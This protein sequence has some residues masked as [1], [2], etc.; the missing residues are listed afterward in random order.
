MALT[1]S[2]PAWNPFFRKG[3]GD[4][5]ARLKTVEQKIAET[6]ASMGSPPPAPH[7]AAAGNQDNKW[8]G[9]KARWAQHNEMVKK[10]KEYA[11]GYRA[12]HAND[13]AEAAGDGVHPAKADSIAMWKKHAARVKEARQRWSEYRK[14]KALEAESNIP[15][16]FKDLDTD[17]SGGVSPAELTVAL[18]KRYERVLQ[19]HVTTYT[20][21]AELAEQRSTAEDFAEHDVDHDGKINDAEALADFSI[22]AED[23]V[24]AA[25]SRARARRQAEMLRFNK[26]D[27][28]GDGFLDLPDWVRFRHFFYPEVHEMV[29]DKDHEA[30]EAARMF[31]KVRASDSARSPKP[32]CMS[33]PTR[34]LVTC[35][36]AACVLAAR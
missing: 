35:L 15:A 11:K 21:I 19:D 7:G 8:S 27:K 10:W 17:G 13:G 36:D 2:A 28:D 5:A 12:K 23:N 14:T 26:S 3:N 4:E 6:M 34:R 20:S 22:V 32:Q 25:G 33:G 1:A 29:R 31:E 18:R 30:H 9:A 24:T 16:V